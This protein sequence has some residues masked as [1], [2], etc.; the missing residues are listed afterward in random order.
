MDDIPWEIK[1]PNM[2]LGLRATPC[3]TTNKSPSEL[4]MNRRL[5]TLLDTIHPDS[6]E[7]RKKT[8]QMINNAQ[9]NNREAD[10]GQEVMYR[11][12]VR[13]PR[14]LPGTVVSRNGPSNYQVSTTEGNVVTR[15]ID[16]LIKKRQPG[17]VKGV[18][19]EESE[20]KVQNGIAEDKQIDCDLKDKVT[21]YDL[22]EEVIDSDLREEIIE[23]P[24][25]DKWAEML[26]IPV[27]NEV[28]FS[29]GK[30][31]NK[32]NA[33]SRSPYDR[34]SQFTNFMK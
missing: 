13:G 4:L 27:N 1:L 16:Q 32:I 23:I 25:E 7:R 2:L 12:Y 17:I 33:H 5:H 19:E 34:P 3:T 24:S 18:Q 28:S 14:W 9:K 31:K 30:I 10:T 26:G 15:H 29:G 11:N 22:S 6:C 20:E 21:D 8:Q